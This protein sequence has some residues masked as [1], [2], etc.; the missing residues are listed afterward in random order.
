M[1]PGTTSWCWVYQVGCWV[2]H[3]RSTSHLLD[4][5]L[6]CCNTRRVISGGRRR[7]NGEETAAAGIGCS[8]DRLLQGSAA[9]ERDMSM[10][11]SFTDLSSQVQEFAQEV[12]NESSL[13]GSEEGEEDV[14]RRGGGAER[15]EKLSRSPP[16]P[17]SPL[18]GGAIGADGL[19]DA[20]LMSTP[21]SA[22]SLSRRAQ[23]SQRLGSLF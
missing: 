22:A 11:K 18:T 16:P 14:G 19:D 3:V 1:V 23:L 7:R 6:V 20:P 2:Y 17:H 12:L 21:S 15:R 4:D 9:E 5:G 8:R 13:V 10:W